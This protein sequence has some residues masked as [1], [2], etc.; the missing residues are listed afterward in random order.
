M[1][2]FGRHFVGKMKRQ[3]KLPFVIFSRFYSTSGERFPRSSPNFCCIRRAEISSYD[4]F[5]ILVD[6]QTF[7]TRCRTRW[8]GMGC[9][10][11]ILRLNL[12]VQMTNSFSESTRKR[13]TGAIRR[14]LAPCDAYFA[15]PGLPLSTKGPPTFAR[16]CRVCDDLGRTRRATESRLVSRGGICGLR[17]DR[18]SRKTH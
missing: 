1:I 3:W 14:D 12:M 18:V 16:S 13:P 7:G 9:G 2:F 6:P 11:Y 5:F 15:V 10:L 17:R 8:D 4:I